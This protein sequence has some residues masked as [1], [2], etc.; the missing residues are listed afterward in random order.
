MEHIKVW[1]R[2]EFQRLRGHDSP[3]CCAPAREGGSCNWEAQ[4]HLEVLEAVLLGCKYPCEAKRKGQDSGTQVLGFQHMEQ[5][6]YQAG[7]ILQ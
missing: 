3:H 6:L 4:A 1:G 7:V 5:Q 2:S